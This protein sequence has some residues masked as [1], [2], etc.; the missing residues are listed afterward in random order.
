[1][2]HR[3]TLPRLALLA[4]IWG[5]S[6]LWIK[7]A[8]RGL[9]PVEVTLGRLALG[10]AVLCLIAATRRERIPRSAALWA[11]IAVAALFG[12]AVP[13]LLFAVS[14]QSVNSS[15]AGILNSTT[16]LWTM[17][18]ALAVRHDKTVRLRQFCGLVIG[19]CGAL[20]ICSPW[21]AASGI[22][23]A[24]GIECLGAAASYGVSYVYMDRFLVRRGISP[25]ILSACQLVTASILLA[26]ALGTTGASSPRL[27]ATTVASMAILGL[28]GTGIAYVLNYQIITSDGATAASTVTYLLPIV[29]IVLGAFVLGERVTLQVLTGIALVLGGVALTRR[30]ARGRNDDRA[31]ARAQNPADEQHGLDAHVR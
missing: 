5:S 30:R 26:A 2:V 31:G 3:S 17:V 11:H 14:E 28:A 25:L 12:N 20:L 18:I 21:H 24:G 15:A 16:P 7:L 6:F 29:A 4:L 8:L 22:T 27:D 9:S 23:S 1:M 10:A 13:Y 19:F